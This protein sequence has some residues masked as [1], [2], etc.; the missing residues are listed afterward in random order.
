MSKFD[1]TTSPMVLLRSKAEELE[2]SAEGDEKRAD[3]MDISAAALRAAA[4]RKREQ[5]V[6]YTAAADRLEGSPP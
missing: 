4:T 5:A 1:D 3:E 6:G 2:R